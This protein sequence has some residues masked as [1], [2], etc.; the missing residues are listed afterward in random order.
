MFF[1]TKPNV[2]SKTDRYFGCF[3]DDEIV[4][5]SGVHVHSDRYGISVLGN[6]TTRP[7]YRGKGLATAVTAYLLKELR[8][9]GNIIALNVKNDNI[10]AIRCYNKLGFEQYC[11]YEESYFTRN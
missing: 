8:A 1:S 9:A 7:D 6:I 4:S 11:E 10:A 5:V 2:F 3:I